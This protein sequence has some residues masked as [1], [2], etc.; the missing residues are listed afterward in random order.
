MEVVLAVKPTFAFNQSIIQSKYIYIVPYIAICHAADGNNYGWMLL[1]MI[2]YRNTGYYS[3]N[4]SS[5]WNV[6]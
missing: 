3:V 5:N 1:Y 6:G 4:V 2:C